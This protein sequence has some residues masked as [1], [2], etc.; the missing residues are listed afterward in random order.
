M[1]LL[2][3]LKVFTSV[4][5]RIISRRKLSELKNAEYSI[6]NCLSRN[7]LRFP[8]AK[9]DAYQDFLKVQTTSIRQMK[10]RVT[11]NE[12]TVKILSQG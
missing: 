6:N 4:P 11:F 2:R 10:C 7:K 5:D 8:K 9:D 12:I 3:Y 1:A